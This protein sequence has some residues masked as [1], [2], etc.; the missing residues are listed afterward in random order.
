MSLRFQA[1]GSV[2][3]TATDPDAYAVEPKPVVAHLDSGKAV[4]QGREVGNLMW[5]MMSLGQFTDLWGRWNT[6]KNTS[7]TFVIPPRTGSSWTSW[8]SVT[9]YAEEPMV[10]YR[11]NVCTGVSMRIV[12]TA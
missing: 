10:E 7:G 8:R 12:I 5:S 2:L 1:W 11:G 4:Q 6:N 3:T 9:A